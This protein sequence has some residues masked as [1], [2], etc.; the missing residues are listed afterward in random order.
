[1]DVRPEQI[2]AA[3]KNQRQA[4]SLRGHERVKKVINTSGAY[5]YVDTSGKPS[6]LSGLLPRLSKVYWPHSSIYK[7]MRQ[8]KKAPRHSSSGRAS[9]PPRPATGKGRFQGL[10]T[11]TQ[12]HKEMH[13]FTVLDAKNFHK[14]YEGALHPYCERLFDVILKRQVWLPFLPEF[15]IYD[16][17]LGIGTSIDM[18]ALDRDGRLVL[19]EFKTGYKNYF[20]SEDGYMHGTLAGMRNTPQNQATLQLTSA[21]Q[22]LHR[23]YG[24]PL[25]DMLLYIMRIDDESLDIIPVD[26]QFVSH[27]GHFVY[28]GLLEY[29]QQKVKRRQQQQQRQKKGRPKGNKL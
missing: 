4:Q 1:M 26:A 3:V 25:S 10:I 7:Q 8:L 19:L 16:E 2:I 29:Q 18:V 13:D 12:V 6:P 20:D 24:V 11:G 5:Y 9:H 27:V 15:D 17:A 28:Q 23:Q 22:I 14:V 21:A